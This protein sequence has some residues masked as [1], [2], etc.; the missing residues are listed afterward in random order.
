M[1]IKFSIIMIRLK[2]RYLAAPQATVHA[3]VPTKSDSD[4]IL[5]LQLQVKH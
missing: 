4:V 3:V 1:A 5:G 2:F